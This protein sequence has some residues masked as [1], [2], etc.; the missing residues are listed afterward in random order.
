[1][2]N[3]A[4]TPEPQ[5]PR[6]GRRLFLTT[7]VA[8]GA[9]GLTAGAGVVTPRPANGSNDNN[10]VT[11]PLRQIVPY[12]GVHQAGIETVPPAHLVFAAFDLDIQDRGE[13]RVLLR[14]WTE[15]IAA[16]TT[17]RTVADDTGEATDIGPAALTVTI[18]VGPGVFDDRFG[19]SGRAPRSLRPLPLF[20]GDRI[21]PAISGGD[22]MVQACAEDPTVA[23]HAVRQLTRLADGM[24]RVRWT[25]RGF[26]ATAAERARQ[27]PRN[28]FGQ[29]DGTNSPPPGSRAFG[30]A[31][32]VPGDAEP[33]WL[34]GGSFLIARKIRM[35]LDAWDAASRSVQ[36]RALGR[37]TDNGAPLSGGSEHTPPNFAVRDVGG[38][39]V[40][41][42][43]SHVRLSHPAFHRGAAMVR[44]GYSYAEGPD[45][46]TGNDAG[47]FFIAYV[48][49]IDRQFTPVQRL[50]AEQDRLAEFTTHLSSSVFAVLP[51][52]DGHRYL[53]EA[54][55]R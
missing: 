40:I 53:G 44:R 6:P 12:A 54:L 31:A 2:T 9:G 20:R 29:L 18:G 43:R 19:L 35:D 10:T 21:D 41:D 15:A 24:A 3:P 7:A 32:W 30:N 37:R 22:L 1:M 45:P 26:G 16:L 39:P 25:Q 28:L 4:A 13:L 55:L 14:R 46:A 48:A 49:D 23:L 38:R 50:L 27:T 8:A 42:A 47:L 51:G 33:D 11:D 52:V 34:R 36:E 5:P 17:G